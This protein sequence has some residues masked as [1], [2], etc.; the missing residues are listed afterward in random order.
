M[1]LKMMTSEVGVM[2]SL[3]YAAADD[4]EDDDDDAGD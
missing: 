4:D 2:T 3:E 1:T